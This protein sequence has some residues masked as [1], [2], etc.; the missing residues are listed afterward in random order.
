MRETR[1]PV[2]ALRWARP[3]LSDVERVSG[4]RLLSSLESKRYEG[5]VQQQSRDSFLVGRI[6]LRSLAGDLLGIAP[7]KVA[8]SADCPDC[9]KPHGRP[10][11][12]GVNLHVSLSRCDVAVVAVANWGAAIGVDVEPRSVSRQRER[13][14]GSLTGNPTVAQ[15]TGVEAVLKADGRGL[16]VDPSGVVI[17]G[18]RANLEGS[19]YWLTT[20]DVDDEL[21]VSVAVAD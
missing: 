17:E 10:V 18:H 11:I 4:L 9:S 19:S 12:D 20:P 5:I 15:W 13:A 21:M 8:L 1:K 2:P 7:Q 3:A 14:I 16:R 6:L